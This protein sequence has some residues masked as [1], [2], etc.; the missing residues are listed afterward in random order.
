MPAF[1]S[2][3]GL[4][5]TEINLGTRTPV[6][7]PNNVVSTAEVSTVQLELRYLSHL[8]ENDDYWDKAENVMKI[9]KAA[10][11][12]TGLATIFLG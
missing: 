6:E 3:S 8:L 11:L 12:P 4:P 2:P 5:V 7:D 1:N 9:L 10:K